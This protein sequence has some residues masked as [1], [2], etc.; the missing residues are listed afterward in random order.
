[1]EGL[2]RVI[3]ILYRE[4]VVERKH[5]ADFWILLSFLPTFIISRLLVHNFPEL[6]INIR[7]THIHHLAFGIIILAIAGYLA[8]NITNHRYRPYIA[9]FYGIGL[10]LAFDEFGMWLRL[11]DDY[12]VRQS[13][14]AVLI[15]SVFL[16]NA[17]YFASFWIRLIKALFR[18]LL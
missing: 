5:D 10:A 12:W 13:Y 1:M 9:I 2:L 16:I 7:G 14:D 15:I 6:F 4:L 8:Q 17:V 18:R 3:K 11:T